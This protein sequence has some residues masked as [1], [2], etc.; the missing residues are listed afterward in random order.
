M[1]TILLYVPLALLGRYLFGIAGVFGAYA[2][3]N[4]TTGVVA[5]LW[6]KHAVR[7]YAGS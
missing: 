2:L 7:N 5:Y 4:V 1:R 6:L 3:A